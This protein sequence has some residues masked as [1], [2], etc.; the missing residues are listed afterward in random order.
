MNIFFCIVLSYG[1]RNLS[2]WTGIPLGISCTHLIVLTAVDDGD[3]IIT[4]GFMSS[5]LQLLLLNTQ[6]DFYDRRKIL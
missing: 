5:V 1:Y 3:L 6:N 4:N 2:S